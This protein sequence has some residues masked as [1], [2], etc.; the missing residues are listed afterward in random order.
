MWNL[1][2]DEGCTYTLASGSFLD[3]WGEFFCCQKYSSIVRLW[4]IS[5]VVYLHL[6]Y[7]KC[8]PRSKWEYI[9]ERVC[10]L[11][12]IYLERWDF[13]GDDAGKYGGHRILLSKKVCRTF[14]NL[15]YTTL[16]TF[17]KSLCLDTKKFKKTWKYIHSWFYAGK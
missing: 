4:H 17:D 2:S 9:E 15:I 3:C 14:S 11:I 5:K 7:D 1:I 10:I 8:M 13:S 16:Y 6:R 12:F